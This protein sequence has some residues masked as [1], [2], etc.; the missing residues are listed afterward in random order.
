MMESILACNT[1]MYIMQAYLRGY[2]YPK[3]VWLTYGWYQ[4]RWWT[5]EVNPEPTNCTD[6]QLAEALHRSIA[7]Q[8]LPN[9]NKLN[10]TT[11]TG[12]VSCMH[13]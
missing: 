8:L 13:A 11:D 12:L 5:E 2:T 4:D 6:D 10:S 1:I 9:L 7:L 3:Y